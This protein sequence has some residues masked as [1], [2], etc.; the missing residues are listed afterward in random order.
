MYFD[1]TYRFYNHLMN[2]CSDE[3]VPIEWPGF[4]TLS[5]LSPSDE[6]SP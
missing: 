3:E 2:T 5:R 4:R 1:E 6:M